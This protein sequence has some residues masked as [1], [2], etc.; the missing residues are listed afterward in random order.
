MISIHLSRSDFVSQR[1]DESITKIIFHLNLIAVRG[2]RWWHPKKNRAS[3]CV[4]GQIDL[5]SFFFHFLQSSE[6]SRKLESAS[7]RST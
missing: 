3:V 6:I 4:G 7:K 1:R 2:A 5:K